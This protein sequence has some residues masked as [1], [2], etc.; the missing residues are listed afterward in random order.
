MKKDRKQKP[1][2]TNKEEVLDNKIRKILQNPRKIIRPYISEKMVVLVSLCKILKTIYLTNCEIYFPLKA[3]I[4]FSKPAVPKDFMI[5]E[6]SSNRSGS[7]AF[8]S[9]FQSPRT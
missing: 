1:Y 3:V 6:A 5:S 2:P 8:S 9:S 4:V 7:F